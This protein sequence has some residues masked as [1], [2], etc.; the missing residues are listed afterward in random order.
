MSKEKI[1]TKTSQFI[2]A[3]IVT[4]MGHVDHGKTSLLDAI[5][6]TNVQKKEYGGITQ[7]I[8]ACSIEY[9]NQKITFID[10]PGHSAFTQMRARG[11]KVA[12]IVV[13]VVAAD[14]GVQPQTKEAIAHARA[15]NASIIVAINKM[16]LPGADAEKVK[17][18]LAQENILVESWGGEFVAVEVSAEKKTN[19]DRLLDAILVTAELLEL[20]ANLEGELEAVIIESKKDAKQGVVVNCVIRNGTLSI[21]DEIMASGMVAKVKR[22]MD[23]NGVGLNKA[24]PTTPVSILGFNETPNV[25]DLILQKGSEL[26]ELALDENRV[27]IVGTNAKNMVSVIIKADTRGTL[28][29]VK[30]SLANMVTSSVGNTY[31]LK[32]AH[33]STGPVTDSDVLLA[34]NVKGV[35]LGFNVAVA[36]SAHQLAQSLKIPVKTYKTIYDLI[37]EAQ[38]L[39]TWTA[40]KDEEKIKG[41]AQILKLFKLQSGDIVAGSKILAGRLTEGAPI[42]VYDKDP[43]DLTA[44]DVPL[45]RSRIKKIKIEDKEEKSVGKG[46]ECGIMLKPQIEGLEVGMFLEVIG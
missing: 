15:A 16:D 36:S 41:R 18:Q 7:H 22:I 4:F 14:Q 10:T 25:G 38:D 9:N 13:L 45:F 21:G 8:G 44:E 35:I 46:K 12:D 23:E 32:F 33:S 39:L 11:G 5:R 29:A 2:R 3:P 42:A 20:K 17:Q 19:L 34:Q 30:A 37:D 6:H 43:A 40:E 26:A 27:E 28:E 24:I 31:S 1:E